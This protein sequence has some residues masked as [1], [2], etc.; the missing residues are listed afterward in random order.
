MAAALVEDGRPIVGRV[1]APASEEFF[2]AIAGEGAT[3]NGAAI[4]ATN[5]TGLDDAR[6]SGPKRLVERMAAIAPTLV[7]MPR[8]PSLALRITRVA[9]G[10]LDVAIAGGNSHDWDLA[11]ADL[12]V[13]EAG[14]VMTPFDG[15][16]LIYNRPDRGMGRSLRLD[17]RGTPR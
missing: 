17:G 1:F 11:A 4:A 9:Q 8:V 7:A 12:L 10:V 6:V 2:F 15:G 3:L 16:T 14:G 5:G 13:H